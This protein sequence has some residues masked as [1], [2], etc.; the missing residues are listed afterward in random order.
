M[1]V[2]QP[3]LLA[4]MNRVE[5]VVDV[6]RDPFGNLV[7]RTRNKDRPWRGPCAARPMRS[8]AHAQQGPGVGQILQPRDR[9]LRTQFAIGRRQI[10]RHLEHGIAAQR[11]GVVSVFIS[12]RDHQQAKAEDAGKAVCDRLGRA[13]VHH[14]G[15]EPIGDAKAL[16]DLAQHQTAA[17]GREQTAIELGDDGVAGNRRQAGRRQHRISHGGCGFLKGRGSAST[18]KSYTKSAS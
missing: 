18:T 10:E 15:G 5:R 16:L 3:Q 2:E 17:I 7:A 9:G 11:T 14:A 13:R 1:G 12:R 4:A 6:E 8:N